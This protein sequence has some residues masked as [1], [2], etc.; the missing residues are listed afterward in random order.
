[1]YFLFINNF[2]MFFLF[3][4]LV[5]YLCT[6]EIALYKLLNYYLIIIIIWFPNPR[7]GRHTNPFWVKSFGFVPAKG[8]RN[9]KW[10]EIR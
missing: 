1:M 10:P 8:V 9:L 5:R 3:S 7:C 6:Y 4:F 2:N